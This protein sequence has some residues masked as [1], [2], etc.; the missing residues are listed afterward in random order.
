MDVKVKRSV[1]VTSDTHFGHDK[2]C[3]FVKPDG[4]KVRPWSDLNRMH[5]EMIER[6]NKVVGKGDKVYHLGD[7]AIS[8][9]SLSILDRLNGRKVLIR[10]NHD[11][12]ELKDYSKYFK[13]V[14]GAFMLEGLVFT[15]V[16]VHAGSFL[17]RWRGNVHGHLHW[18]K[19]GNPRY[20]N[21]CVECHDFAPV[22]LDTILEEYATRQF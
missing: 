22:S 3:Q 11:V 15:H 9:R 1:F 21:A 7:V 12:Y 16:P 13:D 20:F 19:L 10:G 14:R 2:I 18:R 4:T 6:W 8:R 5:E 17:G